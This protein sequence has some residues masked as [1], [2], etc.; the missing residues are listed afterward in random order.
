MRDEWQPSGS[1]PSRNATVLCVY[2]LKLWPY[3]SITH[4]HAHR[5]INHQCITCGVS[6][7]PSYSSHPFPF[8]CSRR[9]LCPASIHST[10]SAS[11]AL[12][13]LIVWESEAPWRWHFPPPSQGGGPCW[14]SV[15]YTYMSC[16][17]QFVG[18]YLLLVCRQSRVV[19]Y[20]SVPSL[21]LASGIGF[22]I[23]YKLSASNPLSIYS[24]G[25]EPGAKEPCLSP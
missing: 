20:I 8:W 25:R 6:F 13:N 4:T 12:A 22:L 3:R 17:I 2:Y 7:L 10:G 1:T 21:A 23:S 5:F 19:A 18:I 24:A 15:Q 14:P 11:A 9:L 16:I